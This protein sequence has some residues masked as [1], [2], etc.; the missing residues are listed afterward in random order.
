MCHSSMHTPKSASLPEPLH[1]DL[2]EIRALLKSQVHP[3][4]MGR[5]P[6]S[7]FPCGPRC[8][9]GDSGGNI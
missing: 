2:E 8:N 7:P 5:F 4:P 6:G 1:L 9:D 3:N